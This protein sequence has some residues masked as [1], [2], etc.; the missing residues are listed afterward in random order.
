[1]FAK[2]FISSCFYETMKKQLLLFILFSSALSAQEKSF[3]DL[4]IPA[5]ESCNAKDLRIPQL[6]RSSSRAENLQNLDS[7][8]N[9]WQ[10]DCGSS[11]MQT[12]T[13]ILHELSQGKSLET[14][15][16]F[17][18]FYFEYITNLSYFKGINSHRKYLSYT[19]TW[20][21][22]L[23]NSREWPAR[24]TFCLKIL[25]TTSYQEAVN[26]IYRFKSL[27]LE[28]GKE[29]EESLSKES[30]SF[31]NFDL[32]F[33]YANTNYTGAIAENIGTSHGFNISIGSSYLRHNYGFDFIVSFPESSEN[34]RIDL[35]D[36]IQESDINSNLY[37]G[38]YYAYEFLKAPRTS[39]AF[40]ATLGYTILDTDLNTYD[41]ETDTEAPFWLESLS[42][43]LGLEWKVRIYGTRQIGIRS[44]YNYCNFSRNNELRS[45][46]GG[47]II[48]SSL[49]FQF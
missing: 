12:R 49:F 7:L 30:S 33:G 48:Q 20:A 8:L 45:N 28:E 3:S 41:A 46:L 17:S 31:F 18:D 40:R 11:E 42:L 35:E 14:K 1:M 21:E 36:V 9:Y 6:I 26:I 39:L 37:L 19:A 22:E 47:S 2:F 10:N 32:V 23:L 38:G 4:F 43:G 16:N 44:S 27:N 24:E 13:Q 5:R 34:L 15:T 29:T 25:S